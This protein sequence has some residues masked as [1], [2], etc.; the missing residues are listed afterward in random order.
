M[1]TQELN[2]SI[3]FKLKLNNLVRNFQS[4]EKLQ[5]EKDLDKILTPNELS[6]LRGILVVLI[7]RLNENMKK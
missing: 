3:Y 5:K 7:L 1:T 6:Y 4:F 2:N